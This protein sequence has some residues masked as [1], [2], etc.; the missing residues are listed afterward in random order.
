MPL[1]SC[2]AS[3]KPGGA[4]EPDHPQPPYNYPT[5]IPLSNT[6]Y[7]FY[8]SVACHSIESL[9]RVRYQVWCAFGGRLSVMAIAWRMR[10]IRPIRPISS[11]PPSS[12]PASNWKL[13]TRNPQPFTIP[14]PAPPRPSS[15]TSPSA[16]AV[17]NGT[18]KIFRP[19]SSSGPES[20]ARS[21]PP[22]FGRPVPSVFPTSVALSASI[23]SSRSKSA[24]TRKP[25]HKSSSNPAI[26]PRPRLMSPPPR[27]RCNST[28]AAAAFY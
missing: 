11:V 4:G 2:L 28:T 21:C 8:L 1:Q 5:T 24:N 7:T 9:N 19:M 26:P 16:P 3:P 25:G 22:L 14:A 13:Q 6:K 15:R 10:P 18:R 12:P 20:P 23:V 27:G 17:C